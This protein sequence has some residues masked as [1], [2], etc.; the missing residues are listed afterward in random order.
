MTYQKEHIWEKKPEYSFP[1]WLNL[2]LHKHQRK[3]TKKRVQKEW[4]LPS[5]II[6]VVVCPVSWWD[7]IVEGWY[8]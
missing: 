7:L 4:S 5:K 2:V 8:R 3:K 6:P 1:L